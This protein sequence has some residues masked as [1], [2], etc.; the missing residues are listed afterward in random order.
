MG[1]RS[2]DKKDEVFPP[3]RLEKGKTSKIQEEAVS[4]SDESQGATH[5]DDTN[6]KSS[7]VVIESQPSVSNSQR[8]K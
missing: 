3:N 6:E 4:T 8:P 7:E 5:S 1:S 2:E